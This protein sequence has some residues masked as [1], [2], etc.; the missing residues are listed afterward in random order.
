MAAMLLSERWDAVIRGITAE[1][2]R[3]YDARY[4]NRKRTAEEVGYI[5]GVSSGSHMRAYRN[6]RGNDD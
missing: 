1:R 4:R 3:H 5:R 2:R 6:Q